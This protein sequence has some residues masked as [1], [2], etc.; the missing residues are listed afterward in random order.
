MQ[1]ERAVLCIETTQ[2]RDNRSNQ[3]RVP[4]QRPIPS[5]TIP[6]PCTHCAL[7]ER[8]ALSASV[9]FPMHPGSRKRDPISEPQVAEIES[10]RLIWKR[11]AGDS[12]LDHA[13]TS[14]SQCEVPTTRSRVV[15]LTET[16]I[17]ASSGVRARMK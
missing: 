17:V 2:R 7:I 15:N 8:L 10:A 4:A 6:D 14:S 1:F 3:Q 5:A 12:R 16:I 13:A 9:G 11:I